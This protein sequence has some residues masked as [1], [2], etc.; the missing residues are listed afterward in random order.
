[1]MIDLPFE[2]PKS[3][4][5]YAEQFDRYPLK[6]ISRL[7]KHLQKRGPDAVGYFLLS[8]FYHL[9]GQ[10]DEAVAF[11]LKAKILAP[12]SPFFEKLHYYLSHPHSFEAWTPSENARRANPLQSD[13]RKKLEPVL[14][15]DRLISRLSELDSG[16]IEASP[17][18]ASSQEAL[19]KRIKDSHP[20]VDSIVSET[21]AGIHESQGKT[22]A[23]IQAYKRLKELNSDK[24]NFYN[25]K[26]SSL[27]K[28]LREEKEREDESAAKTEQKKKK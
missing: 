2:L 4:A 8:W 11:S 13:S 17:A 25:E 14:D 19:E 18:D 15:L 5:S 6:T 28:T 3:L 22:D 26:I 9:Q 16:K 27:E 7:K 21:L 10:Q 23:A 12:G 1:M 24:E 20:E